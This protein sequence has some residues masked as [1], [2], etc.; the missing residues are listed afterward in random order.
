MDV[1]VE[2][3]V[4]RPGVEDGGDC[5]LRTE[6]LGVRGE[7][8]QRLGH[9]FDQD[10]EEGTAVMEC[11]RAQ[12]LRHGEHDVEVRRGQ[13]A[14]SALFDPA[15]LFEGVA[16]RTVAVAAGVEG[17]ALEA[18]VKAHVDVP[19]QDRCPAGSNV[20]QRPALDDGQRVACLIQPA[21]GTEDVSNAQTGP[22]RSQGCR[23]RGRLMGVHRLSEHLALLG[24]QQVQR[25]LGAPDVGGAHAGVAGGGADGTVA[26]QD[27]D[28]ADVRT[29]LQ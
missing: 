18:A 17:G 8:E 27:L 7:G 26:Q 24:A 23:E 20:P 4:S 12:L 13:Q 14:L 19:A 21:V 5:G 10:G 16:S 28:D 6:S 11:H 9:G 22:P 3:E 1:G 2:A 29:R 25:T 15:V